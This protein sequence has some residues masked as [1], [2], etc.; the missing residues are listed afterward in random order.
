MLKFLCLEDIMRVIFMGSPQV[1]V[2]ALEQLVI[3]KYNIVAVYT[4][5][6]RPA[7]RGRSL[8]TSAVKEAALQHDLKVMQP[9]SLRPPEVL[10]ELAAFKPDVIVVC[11]FG[12]ILPQKL[13]EIPPCQCLNVHYSLLPRHRGASPV[14][15]AILDG[16]EF[17][18]VSVQLV[19]M[20]LDTGPLLASAAIPIVPGDTTG[21][22]SD[23]LSIIG[24]G[25]IEEALSGWLRGEISPRE[26]DESKAT[27]FGQIN[28][29]EGEIDWTRPAEEIWRRVRA[30]QP[31]PGTYTTWK[32][33]QLKI[34]EASMIAGETSGECGKV[35]SLNNNGVGIIT[36]KGIL[37][38]INIQPEGKK[39]MQAASFMHGQKDFIGSKL[40]D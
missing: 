24:A 18:G 20:K 34:N 17:T 26:Q 12:Q 19:R 37:H 5:P 27:Y 29:E 7:G 22:L 2:P 14:M 35:V 13:L 33:K 28:K 40:Q 10:A 6:D 3:A 1:A 32:G 8:A 15:A 23:K 30:F 36:G 11:A 9:E 16:D 21:T 38:I 25:L 39:P 31:W 4:Q